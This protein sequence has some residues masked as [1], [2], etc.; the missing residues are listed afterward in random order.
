MKS[1]KAQPKYLIHLGHPFLVSHV[2]GMRPA[3]LPSSIRLR[4]IDMPVGKE[5]L[6]QRR[7]L[8]E[9]CQE[10]LR[11]SSWLAATLFPVKQ[12][13]FGYPDAL[14]ELELG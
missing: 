1:N 4:L 12:S 2:I 10:D 13:T 3:R 6:H 11:R 5:V 7:L 9:D 14:S 8:R